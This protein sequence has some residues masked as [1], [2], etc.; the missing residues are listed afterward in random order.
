LT[1]LCCEY[2]T[3]FLLAPITLPTGSFMQIFL[4]VLNK[5]TTSFLFSK[6]LFMALFSH[7]SY[8]LT[9]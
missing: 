7:T 4:P 3:S 1:H 5:Q 6:G 2:T 9:L 8:W